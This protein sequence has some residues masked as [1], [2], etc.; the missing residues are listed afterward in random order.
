MSGGGGRAAYFTGPGLSVWLPSGAQLLWRRTDV[1]L[2][3]TA[4]PATKSLNQVFQEAGL[5]SSCDC[6][7]SIAV[8][9]IG[10]WIKTGCSEETLGGFGGFTSCE[11]GTATQSEE[12]TM[13]T[14]LP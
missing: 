11:K 6:S 12:R 2:V 10:V 8:A 14:E 7:Y 9:T 3:G 1:G 5:C 4:P 13:R